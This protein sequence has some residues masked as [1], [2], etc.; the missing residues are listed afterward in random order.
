MSKS[1]RK[2]GQSVGLKVMEDGVPRQP[3]E[4]PADGLSG[5]ARPP[6]EVPGRPS[7]F[8]G[9]IVVSPCTMTFDNQA[10]RAR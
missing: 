8:L 6:S 9:V 10:E 5:P 7:N 4:A 2:V 3:S 1:L